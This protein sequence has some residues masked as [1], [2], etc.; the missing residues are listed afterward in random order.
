MECE[1]NKNF[2][3][4]CNLVDRE[5]Y[6]F[7]RE[8]RKQCAPAIDQYNYFERAV[9]GIL[10]CLKKLTVETNGGVDIKDFGYFCHIRTRGKYKN[11]SEKNPLKKHIKQYSYYLWFYPCDEIGE[12]YL[13]PF[14][15]VEY[16]KLKEYFVI[17]E[18]A[19]M[20]YEM[21][22]HSRRLSYEAKDIK[23]IR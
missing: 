16:K 5:F 13:E 1:E 8:N 21:E 15:S 20:R 2:L 11:L 10:K 23:F 19:N 22:Q 4:V 12:W 3:K 9:G 14:V 18:S 17:P 6:D 7:Y